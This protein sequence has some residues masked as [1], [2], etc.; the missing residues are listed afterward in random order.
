MPRNIIYFSFIPEEDHTLNQRYLARFVRV[1]VEPDEMYLDINIVFALSKA[2]STPDIKPH[3]VERSKAIARPK[4]RT[5]LKLPARR[6]RKYTWVRYGATLPRPP[7]PEGPLIYTPYQKP[8]NPD[9]PPPVTPLMMKL[10]FSSFLAYAKDVEAP[11]WEDAFLFT[12]PKYRPPMAHD[13][14]SF[15]YL[16]TY[17]KLDMAHYQFAVSTLDLAGDE[18]PI[19][20]LERKTF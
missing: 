6:F 11:A 7:V 13:P 20:E 3:V 12:T 8:Q 17:H 16:K 2:T 15:I 9:E 10:G 18:G 5:I 1:R 14:N 4:F 19:I